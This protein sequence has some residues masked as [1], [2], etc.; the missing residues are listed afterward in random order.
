MMSVQI[1]LVIS[2]SGANSFKSHYFMMF[3]CCSFTARKGL[4]ILIY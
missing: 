1:F 4:N 2:C 3:V